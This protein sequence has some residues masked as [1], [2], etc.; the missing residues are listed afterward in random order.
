MCT[1]TVTHSR[2]KV[3]QNKRKAVFRN[4][5]RVDFEVSEIDGCLVTEGIRCDN[6]VSRKDDHSVM[7]ELKG[8]DVSHACD[9]LFA[10]VDHPEV[11]PLLK[12]NIGFLIVCSKY[13]RFDT[14]VRKA[15]DKA[16][17]QYRAGFHVVKNSCEFDIDRVTAIDGP[18]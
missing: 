15:K 2:V 9:Q 8:S 16:M 5:E 17:K 1:E 3:E 14:F 7:I 6:L 11:T 13:P 18:N 10:S 12:Q 4:E